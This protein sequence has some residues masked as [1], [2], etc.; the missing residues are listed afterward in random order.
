MQPHHTSETSREPI[1]KEKAPSTPHAEGPSGN[2][3]RDLN[4]TQQETD[5]QAEAA[6]QKLIT[7][8]IAKLALAGHA[9][10]QLKAGGFMVCKYGLTKFCRDF[11]ELH[12][13][14]VKLGVNE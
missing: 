1:Q 6:H 14:A 13:F 9:V 10:H 7:T 2:P 5:A 12:A 3:N 4:S 8:Q 11:A